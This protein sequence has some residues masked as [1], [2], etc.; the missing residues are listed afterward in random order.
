LVSAA[1]LKN[2]PDEK[3]GMNV[4]HSDALVFFGATGDLAYKKIF[5]SL[6]ALIKRGN[7]N[8][9]VIGVA[10]A[11]WNVDQLRARA[12][13]SVGKHGGGVD[14]VAFSKLCGLLHYVDGDYKDPVTFQA[15]RKELGSAERPAH[16]LAIPPALFGLVV[17][18]LTPARCTNGARVIVEKPFGHDLVSAQKLNQ[19]L[20]GSFDEE[21]VFR[22]DH[23][24][25]KRAV[26][27][28]VFLRFENA[29]LESFWN[30]N[31]VESV[32]MTMAEDFG[33]QGR[34][35][36]YDQ[37]GTIRDVVQNHLFQILA[38][39]AM[40]PPVRADSETIRDEKVK[41]LKAVPSL[42]VKN[43]VRGQFRS[44]RSE[45]GVAPD[46]NV[47]TFVALRLNVDS[48]RWQGVPFCIRAGKSL[49]VTCT[50]I[51]VRLREPPIVFPT[52]CRA[53][54]YFRF[55]VSPNVTAAFGLTVMDQQEKMIGE[56]VEL[57][58]SRYPG[59]EEADA[60]ER[61]LGDAMAGDATLFAREDYVEEAWRIVDPVLKASTPLYEYEPGTWG[62]SE[63]DQKVSP[64]GGWENPMVST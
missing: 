5:P 31:Q 4:A 19:I 32:Q 60:Y 63:V 45:K 52:C 11:G 42:Q 22:I 13:D 46:S 9:P 47:E 55:R 18:Q 33:V 21:H 62:P 15:I 56:Q 59:A 48:W 6:Q 23:Y 40:E 27:N 54:N 36:F 12:R 35:A 61:V 34:G 1:I 58:A 41:V 38:N 44:Y 24:L 39:L 57:L 16:Y 29:I 51:V 49:P 28:M 25:G 43:V 53:P 50:E 2:P 7:L 10:K 30:H 37:T 14:P 8:V 26:R 20:L 17:E 64:P 3:H